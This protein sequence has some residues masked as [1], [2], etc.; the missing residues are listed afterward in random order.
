MNTAIGIFGLRCSLSRVLCAT[1]WLAMMIVPCSAQ[2]SNGGHF[3]SG[4]GQTSNQRTIYPT[5]PPDMDQPMTGSASEPVYMERRM[6]QLNDVQHKSM[7]ADTDKLLKLVTELNAEI[8]GTNSNSLTPEQLRKVM[9]IEK[10]AHS[11][12]DKMR[13]SVRGAPE[14]QNDSPLSPVSHR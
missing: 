4:S 3:P 14:Y 1:F 6:R 11:V 2:V 10:L 7:V 8:N 5:P 9:E 13:T 12:K